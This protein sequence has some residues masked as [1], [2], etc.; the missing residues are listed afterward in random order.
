MNAFEL[1]VS[2]SGTKKE[3]LGTIGSF[4]IN[5]SFSPKVR[6]SY[7]E[8]ERTHSDQVFTC[9]KRFSKGDTVGVLVNPHTKEV[10]IDSFLSRNMGVCVTLFIGLLFTWSAIAFMLG[11]QNPIT[12]N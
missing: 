7:E 5:S 1:M 4:T 3:K 2:L 6:Y 10:C 12:P 9:W 11:W 8:K